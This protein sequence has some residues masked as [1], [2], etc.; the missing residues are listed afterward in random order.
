MSNFT[1]ACPTQEENSASIQ[2]IL[3]SVNLILT[4]VTTVI[5][6]TKMRAKCCG[7][8]FNMKP[9]NS[10]ASPS[11]VINAESGQGKW[12]PLTAEK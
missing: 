7:A 12:K 10:V 3:I 11:D 6:S 2:I 8:E 5:T 1:A 4:F 9:M